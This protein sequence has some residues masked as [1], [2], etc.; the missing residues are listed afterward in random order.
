MTEA[1]PNQYPTPD[2][3]AADEALEREIEEDLER[4]NG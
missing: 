1:E 2:Q 3:D 4:E